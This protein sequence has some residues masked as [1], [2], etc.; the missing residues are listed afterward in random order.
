MLELSAPF[1]N[2]FVLSCY[3]SSWETIFLMH[4]SASHCPLKDSELCV[5]FKENGFCLH[6]PNEPGSVQVAYKCLCVVHTLPRWSGSCLC[7]REPV[8]G[9]KQLHKQ[10]FVF[11][12]PPALHVRSI[13][14]YNTIFS[15]SI[16]KKMNDTLYLQ[17]KSSVGIGVVVQD[18]IIGHVKAFSD[19]EMVKERRLSG[20]I[21]H[22]HHGDICDE[23]GK[24]MMWEREVIC[25]LHLLPADRQWE[26]M[27][28]RLYPRS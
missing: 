4:T 22:V 10:I 9:R 13:C 21:T 15:K 5:G 2:G 8:V 28:V 27:H 17:W 18:H 12:Q 16:H 23:Q 1:G 11:L 25:P 26:L 3:Y 14:T 24:D 19:P 6:F 20:D 7:E